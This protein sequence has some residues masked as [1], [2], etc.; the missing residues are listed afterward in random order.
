MPDMNRVSASIA[1]A[2][3]TT[4]NGAV[5]TILSKLPFLVG[6]SDSERQTMLKMGDKTEGTHEKCLGYMGSNPEFLPGF[7]N[8]AE[9]D[10]DQALRATI[11]QFYPQLST[12]FRAVDD[13]LMVLNSELWMADLAYYQN[14]R[15][16]SGRG[17][18]GAQKIYDDLKTRFPG[19]PPKAKTP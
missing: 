16:A 1:S 7:V 4:I 6:L 15:E 2:D 10:K 13:T 5:A 8:K 12:M 14:V 3:I 18:P 17:V 9:V 19:R 11:M